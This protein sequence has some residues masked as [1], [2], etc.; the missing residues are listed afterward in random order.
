LHS[1]IAIPNKPECV[2]FVVTR[3]D[4]V[5]FVVRRLER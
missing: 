1:A 5:N 2:I 4:C 3:S